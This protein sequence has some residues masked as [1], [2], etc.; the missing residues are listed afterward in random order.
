M[1]TLK[2]Q[3]PPGGGD[4]DLAQALEVKIASFFVRI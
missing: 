3:G 4:E 1:E 2:D